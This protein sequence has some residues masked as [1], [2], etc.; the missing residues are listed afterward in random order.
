MTVP[1]RRN[2]SIKPDQYIHHVCPCLT[3]G[4]KAIEVKPCSQPPL[5]RGSPYIS[6]FV[7]SRTSQNHDDPDGDHS[8]TKGVGCFTRINS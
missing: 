6:A 1:K 2:E 5:P 3:K 8:A 7:F 4:D